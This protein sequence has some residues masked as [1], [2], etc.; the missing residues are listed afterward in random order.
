MAWHKNRHLNH[1]NRKEN[2]EINSHS[3][4]TLTSGTN[5]VFSINGERIFISINGIRK[6][7]NT[8]PKNEIEGGRLA[9]V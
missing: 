1:C 3:K 9:Q 8:H 4:L 7:G 6:T 5:I 2:V